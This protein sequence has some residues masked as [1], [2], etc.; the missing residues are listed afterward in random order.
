MRKS[1]VKNWTTTVVLPDT[2]APYHHVKAVN[3]VLSFIRDYQPDRVLILGDLMDTKAP[4][5]WSK[6]KAPE[7][8]DSLQDEID[9]ATGILQTLRDGH[10]GPIDF[11]VGNHEERLTKYLEGSAPALGTLR[12]LSLENLLGFDEL[13]IQLRPQPYQLAPGWLGIHGD[14]LTQQGGMS[15]LKMARALGQSVVQGHSH[16][17]GIATE[18]VGWG[19][20]TSTTLYG[21]E[22]GHLADITKADYLRL[23]RGN[24][25]MGFSIL[26][27]SRDLVVPQIVPMTHYGTFMVEGQDY[28]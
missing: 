15:G 3:N 19:A 21:V 7:F 20:E 26:R 8:V 16:R 13:G 17:L 23:N 24:W 9:S 11:L 14:K 27:M 28:L 6:G 5:R 4:A 2:H 25:T 12:A 1:L 18:S 10:R 22:A